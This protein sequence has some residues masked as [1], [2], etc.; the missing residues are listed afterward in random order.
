MAGVGL[1]MGLALATASSAALS[2]LSADRAGVG[3]AVFQ[4]FQKVGGP[5]GSAI[6]GSVLVATY[7]AHLNLAG[8]SP[9]AAEAARASVFGGVTVAHRLGSTALFDSVRTSFVQGIDASILVSA[10][11]AAAGMVLTLAFLP[12]RRAARTAM[13]SPSSGLVVDS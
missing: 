7:R 3:S 8:L 1:G 13:E 6:L 2:E 11:I 10:G 12:G 9:A 4:A 5:F